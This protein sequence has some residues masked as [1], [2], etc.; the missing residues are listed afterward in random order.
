MNERL[1]SRTLR[2]EIGQ[3]GWALLIY[4]LILN[5][6][7]VFVCEIDLLS[8]GLQAVVRSDN[9]SAFES[10]IMDSMEEVLY[11]NGWGYIAACVVS[12]AL[13]PLWKGKRFFNSVFEAK[14]DMTG[15]AFLGL[16]CLFLSGQMVFQILAM[17]EESILNLFGLSILESMEMA[18]AGADTFSMFLYMGLGA[19]IVEEIVFRGVILDGLKP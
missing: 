15:K 6:A 14:Q 3:Y 10:G 4:Y 18:S 12:V 2:R 8:R 1:K 9:W 7:V 11:G 13:I 16:L 5:Y 19:P 17:I